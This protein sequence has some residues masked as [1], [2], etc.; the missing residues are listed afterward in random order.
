MY[1]PLFLLWIGL[2]AYS[3]AA[4]AAAEVPE[5]ETD[6]PS[7]YDVS[8]AKRSFWQDRV[9]DI[10][11]TPQISEGAQ[12]VLYDTGVASL[13]SWYPMPGIAQTK[14]PQADCYHEFTYLG[15][16][17]VT[18]HRVEQ[19]R[20]AL[21]YRLWHDRKYQGPILC[22]LYAKDREALHYLAAYNADGLMSEVVVLN[23]DFVPIWI[24]IYEHTGVYETS[25][26]TTYGK[27]N[28]YGM[29]HREFW[30]G[31]NIWVDFENK[32]SRANTGSVR[33]SLNSLQKF[34]IKSHYP[35][36]QPAEG[37]DAADSRRD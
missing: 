17:L 36:P 5:F 4:A 34:G 2:T 6:A 37:D 29:S 35:I 25:L 28:G 22:T 19:G 18:V 3:T 32:W 13:D 27:A 7:R 23:S 16:R 31:S 30:D 11:L 9:K 8:E 20:R 33:A 15:G 14:P 10:L 12:V 1:R 24:S 21:T 26:I